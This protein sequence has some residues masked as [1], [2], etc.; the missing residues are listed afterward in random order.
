VTSSDHILLPCF[1][2][3]IGLV[4]RAIHPLNDEGLPEAVD[5]VCV[6][7]VTY[8]SD[9]MGALPCYRARIWVH[10]QP[11]VI[12]AWPDGVSV[13]Q[14][15]AEPLLLFSLRGISES[16]QDGPAR[17]AVLELMRRHLYGEDT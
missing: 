13:I 16:R 11:K 10:G 1:Q 6:D 7:H 9:A 3:F 17:E 14:T 2:G 8:T 5:G 4:G 12:E 15:P